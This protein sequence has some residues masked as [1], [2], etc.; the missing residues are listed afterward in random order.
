MALATK[1]DIA[2][3]TRRFTDKLSEYYIHD[4]RVTKTA[5]AE[6]HRLKYELDAILQ[7]EVEHH[8]P[9]GSQDGER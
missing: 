3:L 8:Y 9:R 7:R 5:L 2:E 4:V 6:M 1:P